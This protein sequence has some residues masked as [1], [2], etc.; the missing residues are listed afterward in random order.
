MVWHFSL[1]V[2]DNAVYGGDELFVFTATP[3]PHCGRQFSSLRY[4]CVSYV[5]ASVFVGDG[6]FTFAATSAP[7]GFGMKSFLHVLLRLVVLF[8]GLRAG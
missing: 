6:V 5:D 4:R 8:L 7:C 3:P 1:I 2:T